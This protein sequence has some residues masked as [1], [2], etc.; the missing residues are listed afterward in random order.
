MDLRGGRAVFL[1]ECGSRSSAH[2]PG[3]GSTPMC[4]CEDGIHCTQSVIRR[5]EEREVVSELERERCVGE[6]WGEA[7]NGE[8][9]ST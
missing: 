8:G 4:V 5:K 9:I 1:Q 3:D 2:V 7:G 6:I